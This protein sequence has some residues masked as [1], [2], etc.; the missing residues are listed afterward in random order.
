MSHFIVMVV[1]KES[2]TEDMISEIIAP[3]HEFE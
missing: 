2:P 3:W 1:T